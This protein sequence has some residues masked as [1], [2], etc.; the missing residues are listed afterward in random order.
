MLKVQPKDSRGYFMLPQAPEDAG[1]YVYG[2]PGNGAGQYAHSTALSLIFFV[3]REWAAIDRR[4]FGV[5]NISL[6]GGGDY[7]DHDSHKDGL[8]IDVR[9]IRTDGCQLPVTYLSPDYDGDA[10]AQLIA[11]F[12]SHP[13][14]RSI[15][16]NGP[17]P[18]VTKAVRHDDH[19]HVNVK[20]P[21]VSKK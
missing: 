5:G 4:K 3:E 6:S 18:G 16:F 12:R 14:V 19:F 11:I 15:L 2:T 8:Q 17:V 9:L 20:P 1:Y 21:L 7:P 13:S 10:T